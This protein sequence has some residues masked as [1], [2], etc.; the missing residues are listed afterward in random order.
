MVLEKV[1]PVDVPPLTAWTVLAA[2]ARPAPQPPEQ[3]PG[4][5]RALALMA[6]SIWAGVRAEFADF[7]SAARP[8]TCGVAMLV[9]W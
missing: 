9:P 4:R 3:V 6:D 7:S 1:V 8:A 2:S 5:A